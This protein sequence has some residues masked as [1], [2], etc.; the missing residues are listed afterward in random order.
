MVFHWL[1]CIP[2]LYTFFIQISFLFFF[3]DYFDSTTAA[4]LVDSRFRSESPRPRF[5][6]SPHRWFPSYYKSTLIYKLA[7]KRCTSLDFLK[8]LISQPKSL[9][10]N[11]ISGTQDSILRIMNE[12]SEKYTQLTVI[13]LRQENRSPQKNMRLYV[14]ILSVH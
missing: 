4:V 7:W 3:I 13:L 2:Y 5:A 9:C 8:S 10:K 14:N 1:C 11:A 12:W 6:F